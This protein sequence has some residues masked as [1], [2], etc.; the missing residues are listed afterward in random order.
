MFFNQLGRACRDEPREHLVPQMN[1]TGECWEG[2]SRSASRAAHRGAERCLQRTEQ[3][4][5]SPS[6]LKATFPILQENGEIL[7]K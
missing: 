6:A 3:K 7:E 5:S 1:T 4:D 2:G